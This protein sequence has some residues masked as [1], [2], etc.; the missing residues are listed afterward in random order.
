[1]LQKT[2]AAVSRPTNLPEQTLVVMA[3]AAG[4]A[5]ANVYA[6]QPLL[7]LI[8]GT[9]ALA[10]SRLGLAVTLT[11]VGYALGLIL[12]APLG[13]RLDRRRLIVA[14]NGLSAVVL[15][16][17][18]LSPNA[19]WL[20][21][22]L[23]AVGTLAVSVQTV[24]AYA[25]ALAAPEARGAAVGKVTSGVVIG[26][27]AARA[28]SGGLGDLVGWRAAYGVSAAAMGL[29]ALVLSRKLPADDPTRPRDAYGAILRSMPRLFAD[30]AVLRRRAAFAFVIFAAFNVLWTPMVLA[31]TPLGLSHSQVGLFGLIGLAGAIAARS[32]GR[33]ADRG[34]AATV[35]GGAFLLLCLSWAFIALL[36]HGLGWMALGVILLDLAVQAVHVTNQTLI[37]ARHPDATGRVIAGYMVFYSLG[38]AIGALAGTGLY[39]AW[40]WSGVCLFGAGLSACGLLLWLAERLRARSAPGQ[41]RGRFPPEA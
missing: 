16:A 13:D 24:V 31:L 5:V 7:D 12:V 29:C 32:A 37:V 25:G 10:P 33:Q 35:T 41:G 38:S 6:A 8:G 11:Q 27:L 21:A 28:V 3:I 1:M 15:A 19:G 14:Q 23:A 18:A 4:L 34:R 40:G 20:L 36:P 39:A 9:F 26:I 30:D 17:T 22:S 2:N